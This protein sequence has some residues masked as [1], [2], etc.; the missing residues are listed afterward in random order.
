[1]AEQT[2]QV[3]REELLN[4]GKIRIGSTF[5]CDP[6]ISVRRAT[7]EER[8]VRTIESH[9][10]SEEREILIILSGEC[11]CFLEGHIYHLL[12]G[13]A[14]LIDVGE[15]HQ[16][17]YPAGTPPGRHFWLHFMPEHIIY[18]ALAVNEKGCRLLN[19]LSGYHHY[20][21]HGQKVLL[22]AWEKTKKNAAAVEYLT[23]L[24]LLLTLRCVQVVQ[25]YNDAVAYDGYNPEKR[26]RYRIEKVMEYIDVQCGIQCGINTLAGLAGCS[27]TSLIRNFRRIA[28]CSVLEYIN[29][30]RIRRYKSL[31]RPS[32]TTNQPS[33]LKVCA[34][35]LG[36]SSP[37][38]FARWR[39]QHE[40]ELPPPPRGKKKVMKDER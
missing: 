38:A 14:L 37:Q 25:L 29:R 30:Q 12:S 1:M 28:G 10:G 34:E 18:T 7:E 9:R 21:P 22:D 40:K 39:K 2:F 36:F 26:N 27:R 6:A 15:K 17:F 19:T 23:E 8:R 24:E 3:F 20:D 13:C 4:L 32:Y 31:I 16:F 33:P 5:Y 35:E 11:D